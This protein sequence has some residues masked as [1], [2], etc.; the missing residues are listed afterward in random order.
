MSNT[1]LTITFIHIFEAI[2]IFL[3]LVLL[4]QVR[5][6]YFLFSKLKSEKKHRAVNRPVSRLVN[7]KTIQATIDAN[8]HYIAASQYYGHKLP[9]LEV[10]ISSDQDIATFTNTPFLKNLARKA[11]TNKASIRQPTS[12][13]ANPKLTPEPSSTHK[14][15]LNNYIDDFFAPSLT[16]EA[17]SPEP[18]HSLGRAMNAPA[19]DEIITVNEQSEMV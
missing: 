11:A 19:N 10:S 15:I 5:K 3:V 18:L 2:S 17:Q 14:A 13:H 16:I 6:Q 4:V 12:K 8:H 9:E 1:I 7:K